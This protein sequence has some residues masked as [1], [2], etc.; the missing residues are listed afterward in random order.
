[1]TC[2]SVVCLPVSAG[3]MTALSMAAWSSAAEPADGPVMTVLCILGTCRELCNGLFHGSY[4]IPCLL[5]GSCLDGVCIH[6]S[7]NGCCL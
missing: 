7:C 4:N 5:Q 1:M 6:I 3:G 2:A